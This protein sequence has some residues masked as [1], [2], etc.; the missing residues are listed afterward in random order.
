M[1]YPNYLNQMAA[2]I[3]ENPSITVREIATR[4]RFADSKSVYYWLGKGNLSGINEFKRLVLSG[5]EQHAFPLS[6]GS[7]EQTH[8][9][10]TLP[11]FAW[12]PKEKNPVGEW[13]HLDTD[14]NPQGLFALEVGSNHF[15]PWFAKQDVL[16]VSTDGDLEEQA[17]ILLQ[18][19]QEFLL[20]KVINDQ[21]VHPGTLQNYPKSA[22]PI[23]TVLKQTRHF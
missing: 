19:E 4:L 6:I 17:W 12:N 3:R 9:A 18:T 13:H 15:S 22:I 8:Y 21:L 16:V 14:P 23:G 2:L 1:H 20:A 10:I 7:G 5:E 11:L